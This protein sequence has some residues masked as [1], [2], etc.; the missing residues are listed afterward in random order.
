MA[1]VTTRENAR[2][3]L[4]YVSDETPLGRAARKAAADVLD[5]G[6]VVEGLMEIAE[7]AM[8]DTYFATDSRVEAA[9]KWFST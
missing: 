5:A 4:Q 8:P 6:A 7:T 9:R 1:N 3:V 2:L